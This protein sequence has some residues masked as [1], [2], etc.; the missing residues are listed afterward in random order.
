MIRGAGLRPLLTPLQGFA[1][2]LTTS[3]PD[4]TAQLVRVDV[5][6]PSELAP[7]AQ[8]AAEDAAWRAWRDRRRRGEPLPPSPRPPGL[9]WTAGTLGAL[10]LR[11][12]GSRPL[13]G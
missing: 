11:C 2:K 7:E 10:R 8:L 9:T 5:L 12:I 13:E 3:G 4:T 1:R 6:P